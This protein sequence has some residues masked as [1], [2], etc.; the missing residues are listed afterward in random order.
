MIDFDIWLFDKIWFWRFDEM[1]LIVKKYW[2]LVENKRYL[3]F[4]SYVSLFMWALWIEWSVRILESSCQSLIDLFNFFFFISSLYYSFF[5]FYFSFISYLKITKYDKISIDEWLSKK[6][7]FKSNY[8]NHVQYDYWKKNIHFWFFEIL[9]DHFF[10]FLFDRICFQKRY[11]RYKRNRFLE[12][13]KERL[14]DDFLTFFLLIASVYVCS[15]LLE[16]RARLRLK[17][18]K[19][20]VMKRWISLHIIYLYI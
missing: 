11:W 18:R 16:E 5:L 12:E 8:F 4:Q 10:L 9:I 15:H 2:D 7:I 1:K 19:W 20:M 3:I 6:K 14:L 17:E 13:K